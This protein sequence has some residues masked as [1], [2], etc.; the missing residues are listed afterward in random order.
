[1]SSKTILV[2]GVLLALV[3]GGLYLAGP[4]NDSSGSK[5]FLPGLKSKLNEINSMDIIGAGNTQ[6]AT[7]KKSEGRWVVQDKDGYPADLA[8]LREVLQK[9]AD[10]EKVEQKTANPELYS[11]L[12]VEPLDDDNASGVLVRLNTDEEVFEIIVGNTLVSGADS[13]YVR[14]ATAQESWLVNKDLTIDQSAV[15]WLDRRL[16]DVASERIQQI[17]VTQGEQTLTVKKESR[18]QTNFEPVD[19]PEDQALRYA[20]VAN[21]MANA[22]SD[23]QFDDV[24]K[25]PVAVPEEALLSA[26]YKT[27]DGLSVSITGYDVN[28]EKWLAVSA[29]VDPAQA[30]QFTTD[31]AE[32]A[33]ID[34]SPVEAEVDGLVKSTSGWW[35]QI[36]DYKYDQIN[37]RLEDLL[38]SQE[39]E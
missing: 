4:S 23:L 27:F 31:L 34:M 26:V 19:K 2:I 17:A 15:D 5:V 3:L 13:S 12:G 8:K 33:T 36:P 14:E 7:V 21:A 24:I 37:K 20:G 35:Y 10:A 18:E 29:E 38:E 1:M 11:R 25:T 6:K 22:L 16:L 32:A 9:L 28:S 30:T 39:E